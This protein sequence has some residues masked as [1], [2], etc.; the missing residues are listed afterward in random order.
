MQ[1]F[2]GHHLPA[3]DASYDLAILSHVIEH[4]PD[5]AAL[6]REAARVAEVVVVEVPLEDNLSARRSSKRAGAAEVGHLQRLSR[7]SLHAVVQSAG[8][9]VAAELDDALPREVHRFFA[10]TPTR[11]L[12]ADAKWLVRAGLAGAAPGLARRLFTVHHACLCVP[13]GVSPSAGA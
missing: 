9:R 5:P 13:L 11:R 6:L 1:T 3:A 12:R 2:D 4:V 8:L 10:D 7:A